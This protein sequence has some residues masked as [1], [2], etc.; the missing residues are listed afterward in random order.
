[1]PD[2]IGPAIITSSWS[3]P[4]VGPKAYG[5]QFSHFFAVLNKHDR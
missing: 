1:L 2:R 5:A 3:P 4:R